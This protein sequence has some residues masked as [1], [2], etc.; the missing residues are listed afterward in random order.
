MEEKTIFHKII[1]REIP[2]DIRYEDDMVI[3]I[4]DIN[5]QAPTHLLIIPKRRLP[6]LSDASA[7]D[8]TLLGHMLGI[9]HKLMKE[10]LCDDFRIVINNGARAGQSVFQLHF[11]VLAGREFKWPPG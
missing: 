11:H 7:A 6:K 5:P 9:A 3:V 2:A 1:A 4:T 8:M 10:M